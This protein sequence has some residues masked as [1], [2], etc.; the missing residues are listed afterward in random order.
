MQGERQQNA[1]AKILARATQLIT[2]IILLEYHI[3][4]RK[5][6]E[7]TDRTFTVQQVTKDM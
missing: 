3:D 1:N 5:D 7:N 2:R 6:D 4:F